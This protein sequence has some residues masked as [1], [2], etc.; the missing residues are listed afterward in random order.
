MNRPMDVIGAGFG[1]TGTL[2]LKVA[3]ERLGFGPCMHMM[4]L[5]DD[6]RLAA[7]FHKAA[8]GDRGSLRDALA[9]CRSTVDWPGTFFWRE[10]AEEYPHAKVIL[11]V[12][13]P[14]QWYE[15]MEQTILYAAQRQPPA[16]PS[17]AAA[18]GRAMIEATVLEGTFGGRLADREHAVRVFERHVEQVREAIPADRLL[19]FRVAD[20]WAPLCAFLGTPVPDGPFPRLNDAA[21]FRERLSEASAEGRL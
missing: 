4:P 16:D 1:R 5:L 12:R 17:P 11:T 15:S 6:A 20:G 13:D 14:R 7:L 18:A 2:S 8:L 19:E 3:L 10:L 21:A 9:G